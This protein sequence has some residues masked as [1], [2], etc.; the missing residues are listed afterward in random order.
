MKKSSAVLAL[1]VL[2]VFALSSCKSVETTSAMLHNEHGNYDK[3]IEMAKLALKKNP[4]DAEAHF[5]LGISYSYTGDMAAAY[6]EFTIA[7]QLDPKKL[8]DAETDIKS[9]WAKHFNSGL[10]EYQT[11]NAAGAAHEFELATQADPRQIK[12]WLNLAKVYYGMAENDSTYMDKAYS[13]VD[14]LLAK[15]TKEDAEYGNVLALS[16]Q[17]LARRGMKEEALKTFENL[18]LDDPTNYEVVENAAIDYLNQRDWE[19]GAALLRM[20][21]DAE[22]KTNSE[23]FESYYNLGA[24]YLNLKDYPQAIEAYQEALRIEP[25]NKKGMYYLLLANYQGQMYDD[26]ILIGEEYTTKFSD[27][28]NGWRVL[29]LVYKEKGLKIKAEG[30]MKKAADLGQ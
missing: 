9:N 19:S 17:I 13:T 15:N 28:P 25:D 2:L 16:G 26:A 1:L 20:V 27:D 3:A 21:V 30:A 8:A 6:R 23:S 29:G 24:A 11:G 5:Q 4:N 14:T 22:K 10:S 12:G 18:L 7:G